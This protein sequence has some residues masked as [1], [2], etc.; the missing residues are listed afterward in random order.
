MNQK[1][2]FFAFFLIISLIGTTLKA[3]TDG[4]IELI[5]GKDFTGWRA[6]ENQ[7]TWTVVDGMFQ[8]VGKRSHLWYEGEHLKDGFKNFE[9]EVQVKTFKLANSGIYFHTEYQETNWP[10]KGFE[11]QVNNSHV[12]EGDYIEIKRMASLYG[13]RNVYKS[14]AKDD[15]WMTVRAR[16]ESNRVQ[17]WCDGMKTVDYIQ[18]EVTAQ[19][20]KRLSKGT[21]CLQGH[22]ILSK[23]QYRSFKVRRLPDDAKSS[24]EAPQFGAWYDS[25]RAMQGRQFGFIDLN[26]KVKLSATALANYVYATG[27]NASL[28]KT[29][30]TVSEFSTGKN[31][32]LFFGIKVTS[33]NLGNLKESNADYVIGES[34]DLAS[35]KALLKSGKINVWSDKGKVLNAQ[36]ADELLGLA[37][38]NSVAIEIDNISQTPSVEVL[39][40]AKA[41][42]LK[43]TFSGMIPLSAIEKSQYVFEAAKAANLNYKDLY[44]P[45]W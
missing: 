14:F 42:G 33:S 23:S 38:Q 24:I 4:W 37:N 2:K 19:G 29:P 7:G 32:P 15:K 40:I 18:P 1:N 41:K 34:T 27:I 10:N 13:T 45:K 35:A 43:F 30:A 28:V 9:I 20:V 11:I 25:L 17:I 16:V 36:N 39:K 31:L 21:F 22:D 5:N 44:I 8:N 12:G 6:S 26:P 3:Q